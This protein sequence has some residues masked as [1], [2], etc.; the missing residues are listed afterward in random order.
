MKL[1]GGSRRREEGG[2]AD[3]LYRVI[4]E[5]SRKPR[6]YTACGVADTPDGMT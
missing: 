2:S 6:F 5:Q 3:A 1:M 4:V